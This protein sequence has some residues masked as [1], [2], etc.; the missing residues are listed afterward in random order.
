MEQFTCKTKILSGPGAVVRLKELG[1]RRLL[2]VADPYFTKDG[3]ARQI[4]ALSGAEETE[5]FDRIV[6]DPTAQLAAEGTALVRQFQPDTIV[7]L[8]GGSTLDCAKAMAYFSGLQL[9]LVAIPTTSGSGSEVTDF[10][11]LTHGETKHPLIDEKLQPDVAIL[12]SGLLK[13]L[14]KSLI[15]DCGF[16]VLCHALEALAASNA[17]P[18]TD[19]LA[20]DSFMLAYTHLSA[21]FAG[22]VGV[23]QKIHTAA[24]MAGMAFS[25]AGL[26]LC[27]ALAHALGGQFHL[28][29]GRLNAI[30]LPLVL[31]HN[32]TAAGAKYAALAR[33]VGLGGSTDLLAVRNLKN[34]L[35]RLRRELRLPQDLSQ[36]GVELRLVREKKEQIIRDVL[37][38]PCC[39]TNPAPVTREAVAQILQKA[40]GNG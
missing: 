9:C 29:H 12:D 30:L 17:G 7:A 6:P 36:A 11:I 1:S 16:D 38:D 34:A 4:A 8:G 20:R 3:T 39:D 31:E 18:I 40:A 13:Q 25:Q 37:A 32:S 10:A 33:Y 28:P 21:S 2:M 26:G 22:D 19:A 24:T 27:H 35:I 14:P 15:A 23:R 5:V